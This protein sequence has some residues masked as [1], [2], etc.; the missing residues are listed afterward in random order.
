MTKTQTIQSQAEQVLMSNYGKR[1]LALV[2]G[3]GVNVWDADG[4]RYVDLLSG[5]G[6]N[7]LG[8]CH[9]KVV[10]AIKK[11]AEMLIHV[12]NLYLIEPQVE[13]ASL[14]VK[15]SRADKV[16]FCN[17]GTEANEAALKCARRYSFDKY[18]ESRHRIISLFNSFHGR[19][20]GALS[21]TGQTKYQN[22]FQPLI[23][24]VFQVPPR[25]IEALRQ[26]V[27]NTVCAIILEPVQGEGGI[28]PCSAAYIRQVR[29]L[30]DKNDILLIFDEVQCG[31]GR[32]GHLF[33]SEEFGVE[34]DMISLAK[35]LAGGVPIGAMLAKDKC[36]GALVAG[37]H[38][39]TFGGNP[40]SCAAGI[41]AFSTIIEEKLPQRSKELGVEF[42]HCLEK[43]KEK[44]SCIEQ[45]RGMGLMIGVQM[46]F[47]VSEILPILRQRGFLCGQAGPEVLRFLPPL[48]IERGLLLEVAGILDEILSA[49]N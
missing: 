26:A 2:R 28:N 32:A 22:G 23:P 12:S 21:A 7:N 8:H 24:G 25:D 49:R 44:H 31:L 46:K 47:P 15:H 33:A 20:M 16:F 29:D 41:A 17:S 34:P 19:T 42:M 27:D 1:D 35:G 43:L 36:A 5:L 14:L 48:I 39:A 40:L 11:Q 3:E 4:R 18:G 13:L 10:A 9:P 6:V 37:T 30:C 45:V 38:A